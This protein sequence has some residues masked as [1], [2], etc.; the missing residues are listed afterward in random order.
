MLDNAVFYLQPFVDAIQEWFGMCASILL[1]GPIRIQGGRIGVQSVHAGTT[2]GLAPVNWPAFDWKGFQEA[3]KIC[4]AATECCARELS[5]WEIQALHY[6]KHPPYPSLPRRPST[7]TPAA[8]TATLT[9]TA[10][11]MIAPASASNGDDEEIEEINGASVGAQ[12]CDDIGCMM[13]GVCGRRSWRERMLRSSREGSGDWN[14]QYA[15]KSSLILKASAALRRVDGRCRE[16]CD[17]SRWEGGSQ[18]CGKDQS[19]AAAVPR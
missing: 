4:K 17:R 7:A 9:C 3:E 13:I 6:Q 19:G 11:E 10:A 15:S 8:V 14:G 5:K 12:M 16:S 1:A 2:R 18:C